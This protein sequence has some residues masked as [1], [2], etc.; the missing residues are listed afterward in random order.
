MLFS[1]QTAL[2]L[3]QS[4]DPFPVDFEQAWNW[5]AYSTKQKAKNK[6]L[7]NFEK[8]IDYLT[9]WVKTPSGGRPSESIKLSI[10]CFKSF[11]MMA[12]TQKG[13]EIRRYFLECERI[14]K[15]A[16]EIIPAQAKEIEKLKLEVELAR[17]QER[18]LM[19][20][21][22]IATLHGSEMVAL[23][24][25]KPDAIVTKTERVETLV[26]VDEYGRAITRYDG[27]GIT[28]LAR[29]YGFGNNTKACYHWLATIGVS[30]EQWLIEPALVKAK[31]LPRDLIPW[32]DRQHS[33]K[34]GT[35]QMLLG[36]FNNP[37]D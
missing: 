24:L 17:I 4:N 16:V 12:G 31:K 22:A 28:Y 30:D 20:T 7:N 18:L 37:N 32:L 6:L 25:G 35:R 29:R 5:I 23:I 26:P 14:A 3:I 27:V 9:E 34:K 2:T 13:K 19:T 15:Q 36:E 10:D 11:G 1:Q 8:G 21:Q 33:A